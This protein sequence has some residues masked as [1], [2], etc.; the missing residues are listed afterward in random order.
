MNWGEWD[1]LYSNY[2]DFLRLCSDLFLFWSKVTLQTVTTHSN[3][4]WWNQHGKHVSTD[5]LEDE[6]CPEQSLRISS[7]PSSPAWLSPVPVLC[8]CDDGSKRLA[9]EPRSSWEWELLSNRPLN[10]ADAGTSPWVSSGQSKTTVINIYNTSCLNTPKAQYNRKQ[11]Q[12]ANLLPA[13]TATDLLPQR[14]VSYTHLTL[15]TTRSV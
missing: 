1:G 11:I 6:N 15:P 7:M 4:T 3:A 14:P 13:G 12:S 8:D 5:V 2:F 9:S 10:P